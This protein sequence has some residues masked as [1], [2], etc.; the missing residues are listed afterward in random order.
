M[1]LY[2]ALALC[3]SISCKTLRTFNPRSPL[4]V[5]LRSRHAT[6]ILSGCHRRDTIWLCTPGKMQAVAAFSIAHRE[7]RSPIKMPLLSSER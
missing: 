2:P 1:W 7:V 4:H 3:G 6:R 5:D